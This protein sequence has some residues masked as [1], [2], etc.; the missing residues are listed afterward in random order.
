M[1]ITN[2]LA[3]IVLLGIGLSC[4][5]NANKEKKESAE[6]EQAETVEV[7]YFHNTRRCA[8]CK[9]VESVAKEAVE[10]LDNKNVSFTA[11]NV[12]KSE[13]K[14]KAKE[15]GI[16]GQTL[17]IAGGDKKMNITR[18]GFLHARSNPEKLKQI[19]HEKIN[20]LL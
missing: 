16:S 10:E 8:T 12:E 15:L 1:K 11:L 20:S 6:M 13:G 18:E 3:L 4:S 14:E 2:L 5:A 9:A 7:Y 17:L 19:I